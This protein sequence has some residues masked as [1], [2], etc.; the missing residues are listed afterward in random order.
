M[1]LT[2]SRIIIDF[3][4]LTFVACMCGLLL[5]SIVNSIWYGIPHV[6]TFLSDIRV[7][8]TGLDKKR[9]KGRR[10]LDIGSG[11][12]RMVRFFEREYGM[13]CT[14][15]EVDLGNHLYA[16][17]LGL[18]FGSR[19]HLVKGDFYRLPLVGYDVLYMYL[20]PEVVVRMEERIWSECPPGTLIIANAFKLRKHTP[21]EILKNAK[22]EEEVYIYEV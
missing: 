6:A 12:G 19:S 9:L 17:L 1:S 21:K 8:R 15:Y 20:F 22:G 18:V 14:G 16:K 10:L 13:E 4:A 2:L 3:F 11:S 7:M 5:L